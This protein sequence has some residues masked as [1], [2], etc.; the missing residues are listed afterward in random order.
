MFAIVETGGKQYRVQ[1]GEVVDVER[2]PG[3]VGSTIELDRVLLL[4]QDGNL[5]PGAPLVAGAKVLAKVE[6]Q[7][8]GPKLVVFKFKAKKHYR[9]KKGHRQ[10]YTRLRIVDVLPPQGAEPQTEGEVKEHGA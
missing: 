2:L 6:D 5:S 4:S 3:E 1:P 9:K 7:F 10:W 8:R